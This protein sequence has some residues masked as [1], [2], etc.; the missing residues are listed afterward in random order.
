MAT[1]PNSMLMIATTPHSRRGIVHDV[2]KRHYGCDGDPILVWKSSTRTMNASVPQAV[3]DEEY[4]RDPSAAASEFG[5]EFRSD[6]E[7]YITAEVIG[8][9]RYRIGSSFRGL[10]ARSM[11]PLSIHPA[12]RRTA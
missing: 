5:G 11:S 8:L 6:L 2:F 10:P 3:V 12:A 7:N 1:L 4:E 9:A